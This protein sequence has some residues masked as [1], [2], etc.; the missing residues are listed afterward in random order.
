MA[1]EFLSAEGLGLIGR[2]AAYEWKNNNTFLGAATRDYDR[3]YDPSAYYNP[4]ETIYIR[5]PNN[6]L[7]Q[8]GDT[9]TAKDVKEHVVPVVL[10][11]LLSV[12]LT[13]TTT[14]LTTKVGMSNWKNRVLFPAVRSLAAQLNLKIVNKAITQVANYTGD[15]TADLNAYA[16]IDNAGAVLDE[17]ANSRAIRRYCSLAVRQAATLRQSATLQNSFVTP[18][19][20]EITLN[21]RMG[22]LADFDMFTDQSIPFHTT[23][24][25]SRTG[26]TVKTTVTPSGT[27]SIIMT[28]FPVSTANVVLTG[29][30]FEITGYYSVNPITLAST[31]QTKKFVATADASSDSGGDAT[32]TVSPAVIFDTD[33]PLRNITAAPAATAVVTFIADHHVNMAWSEDGLC[34]V[35]PKLAP[36]DSPYSQTIQDPDSGYSFRISKTA[37]VLEN[38]NIFRLDVLYGATWLNDRATRILSK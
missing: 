1:N 4:G 37:E 19:N 15:A 8:E 26:V 36:L 17:L 27:N 24:T 20:K 16:D 28:G 2:E 35:C 33:N 34:V 6:F 31:G 3:M 9:V 13:Y 21:S 5:L 7:T 25:A 11:K 23:S 32:I 18:L 10:E 29:D 38:K 12:P 14:D 30:V 22:R